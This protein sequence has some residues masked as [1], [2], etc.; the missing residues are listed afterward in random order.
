MVT[1]RPETHRPSKLRHGVTPSS[2]PNPNEEASSSQE[3]TLSERTISS[4]DSE[5][6]LSPE[7]VSVQNSLR[8]SGDPA[9]HEAALTLLNM[10]TAL[11]QPQTPQ[12]MLK[13][14]TNLSESIANASLTGEAHAFVR[15]TR[16]Y[17]LNEQERVAIDVLLCMRLIAPPKRV[18]A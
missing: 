2:E 18:K 8:T 3:S 5:R 1:K 4:G 17:E 12:S 16:S 10:S 15:E 13:A 14:S 9:A 7:P 11:P 6:T